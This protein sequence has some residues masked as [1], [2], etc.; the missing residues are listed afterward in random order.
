[1]L[2]LII[3]LTHVAQNIDLQKKIGHIKLKKIILRFKFSK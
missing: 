1:M 2:M 3:Q